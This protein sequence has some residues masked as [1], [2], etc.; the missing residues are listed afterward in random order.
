M[1]KRVDIHQELLAADTAQAQANRLLFQARKILAVHLVSS[2][3]SGK[4][5]LI[6][7]T[8][9]VLLSRYPVGVIVGD[10]KG[11]D[12]AHR[13]QKMGVD[14]VAIE[15][16]GLCHLEASMVAH[17]FSQLPSLQGGFLFIENVGNLVCPAFY[18]LGEALRVVLVSVP[19]GAEKPAKYPPLFRKADLLLL[20]K[21]DLLPHFDFDAEAAVSYARA[22]HPRLAWGWVS[23]RT[24][25]GMK[26]WLAFLESKAVS[27]SV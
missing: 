12:D 23:A 8:C 22:H 24:G 27:T 26:E 7:E 21:K 19:E 10:I 17:A 18:D 1:Q 13:L 4:T 11:C 6:E 15:T 2:P 16:E 14:A 25:E 20:T 9:S 3:G 5:T